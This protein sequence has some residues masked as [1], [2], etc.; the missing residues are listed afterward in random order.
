VQHVEQK[1]ILLQM[2]LAKLQMKYPFIGDVR[3]KGLLL[4]LEFVQKRMTK[5]PF[6]RD[7]ELCNTII[8][9]AHN[10][11]LLLYPAQ[12]GIDGMIGDALLIAPPLT[13]TFSEIHELI[14]RLDKTMQACRDYLYEKGVLGGLE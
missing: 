9:M 2:E 5:Q 6:D 13:I 11:G 8:Q 10:N 3:G 14:G 4:G 1:G 12:A 7:L